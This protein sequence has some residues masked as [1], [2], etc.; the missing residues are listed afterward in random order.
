MEKGLK[1]LGLIN[2]AEFVA[3]SGAF[4]FREY[5]HQPCFSDTPNI[6]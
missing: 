1:V 6:Y 2:Q 3:F 4:R 5:L